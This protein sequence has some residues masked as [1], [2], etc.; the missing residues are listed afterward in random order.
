MKIMKIK[1]FTNCKILLNLQEESKRKIEKRN[2]IFETKRSES[3]FL[4]NEFKNFKLKCDG[5]I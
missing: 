5:F 1:F 3:L 2:K 4:K